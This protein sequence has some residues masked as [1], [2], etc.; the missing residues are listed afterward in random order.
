MR[1][2][3]AGAKRRSHCTTGESPCETR[4]P[5]AARTEIHV[6]KKEKEVG[7][8]YGKGKKRDKIIKTIPKTQIVDGA[9]II[10]LSL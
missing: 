3:H 10:G 4:R 2:Q 1:S 8:K 6:F 5:H 7:K 9:R